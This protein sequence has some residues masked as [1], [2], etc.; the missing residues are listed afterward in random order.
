MLNPGDTTCDWLSDGCN[1]SQYHSLGLAIQPIF[2]PVE[3][4]PSKPWA[5][6][7]SMGDCVESFTEVQVDY[8]HSLSLIY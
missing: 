4:A 8:I 7:F 2:N 6:I 1:F 5:A 3:S